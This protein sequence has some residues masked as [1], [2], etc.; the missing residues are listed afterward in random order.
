LECKC[1][2]FSHL[3][4]CHLSHAKASKKPRQSKQENTIKRARNDSEATKRERIR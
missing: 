2:C 4:V 1:L 3:H